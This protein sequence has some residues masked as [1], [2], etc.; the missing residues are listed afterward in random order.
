MEMFCFAFCFEQHGARSRRADVDV[1]QIGLAFCAVLVLFRVLAKAMQKQTADD[2]WRF[3]E[4]H[5]LWR[6]LY[7]GRFWRLHDQSQLTRD[8]R[9]SKL[10]T[11]GRVEAD[12][13]GARGSVYD[14]AL[15]LFG[16]FIADLIL[17]GESAGRK[18]LNME[19]ERDRLLC[20]NLKNPARQ[21]AGKFLLS[22][23]CIQ[24]HRKNRLRKKVISDKHT[25]N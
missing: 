8:V 10:E 1:V 9:R 18:G 4:F 20:A 14:V 19:V 13:R 11:Q 2:R 17:F 5:R 12:R 25:A 3:L 7:G 16:P 15:A 6:R 23:R 21:Y 22:W 24:R